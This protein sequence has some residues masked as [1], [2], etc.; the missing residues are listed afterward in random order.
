MISVCIL[1]STGSIGKSVFKIIDYE[2]NIKIRLL[3]ANK[4]FKLICYQIKKYK[5]KY[6]IIN[7]H[8]IYLKV[9]KKF[10]KSGTKV[11]NNFDNIK[12]KKRINISISAIPGIAGL[13]PTIKVIKFVNKLL[14]AN[15]ES[16]IC[17]WEIIKR[18]AEKYKT[19]IIP[20]DSE[21]YS[22][23]KLLENHRNNEIKKSI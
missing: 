19:K 3:S 14:I 18:D 4:N 20:V 2:K 16:I 10:K 9:K 12:F 11:L 23:M 22:I 5:P 6:F 17:G 1:G 13:S 7:N 8:K 15:K 21:H